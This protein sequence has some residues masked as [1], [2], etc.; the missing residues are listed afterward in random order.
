MSRAAARLAAAAAALALLAGAGA[1][2]GA[3]PAADVIVSPG[4]IAAGP[5]GALWFVAGGIGRLSTDGSVAQYPVPLGGGQ[6]FDIETGPD[7]NLWFTE[8]GGRVGRITPAGGVAMYPRGIVPTG[9]CDCT[10]GRIAPG[11]DG[12][13]WFTVPDGRW[14]GHVA[15]DGDYTVVAVV[16]GGGA[17]QDIVAGADGNM[18]FTDS[19]GRIGRITTAGAVT[20]FGDRL[21]PSEIAAGPDGNLWFSEPGRHRLGRITPEGVVTE[22]PTGRA[23]PLEIAAGPDGNL[24]FSSEG[25]AWIGRM[26]PTGI[27][28]L[29]P[30]GA[31]SGFGPYG[32]TAGPDGNLW[33]TDPNRGRIARITPD[34]VVSTFP[35]AAKMTAARLM[36]RRAVRIR[37]R[38]PSGAAVD[39]RGSLRLESGL[40]RGARSDFI[41]PPGTLAQIDLA[42]LPRWRRELIEAGRL[43]LLVSLT[44]ELLPHHQFP[45][46]SWRALALQLPAARRGA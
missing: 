20:L 29:F 23:A 19:S 44:A 3:G 11:P 15:P 7:G 33:S 26:A 5:D 34:G 17:P 43:R 14:I 2:L 1:A 6:L 10:G 31:D 38:C 45:P 30:M 16:P 12:N 41:L 8:F 4:N 24:W 27:L 28:R 40:R 18:W 39:C 37:V 36:G 13:M 46:S 35:P 9:P 21:A 32:I 25:G 42:L 22:F